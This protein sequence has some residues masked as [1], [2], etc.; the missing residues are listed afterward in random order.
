M[1]GGIEMLS[2]EEVKEILCQQLQLLAEQTKR[3]D[4]HMDD[5]IAC[6]ETAHSIAKTLLSC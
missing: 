4:V 6:A 2:S 5:L 3:E 1:K